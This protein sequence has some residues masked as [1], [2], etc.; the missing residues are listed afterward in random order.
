MTERCAVVLAGGESRRMKSRLSKVLH[1]ILGVTVIEHVL[2]S[3]S[4]AGI[5]RVVIVANPSNRAPLTEL[6]Q[7][8]TRLGAVRSRLEVV[9]QP[10]ALGTANAVEAALPRL[11][12]RGAAV[13]LCGDAPLI[14]PATLSGFL[15]AHA[16][17]GSAVG[18][19]SGLVDDPAGYGRIVRDGEGRF[20]GIVEEAE[21]DDDARAIREI[22]SGCIAFEIGALR[23]LLP[24][25]PASAKG[26][27]YLTAA[28]ELALERG[29][30]ARAYAKVEAEEILGINTRAQLAAATAVLRRRVVAGHMEAGVSF[31]DPGSAFIDRRARIGA[32]TVIEPW[33]VIEGPVEVGEGCRLGPFLRLRGGG[34]VAEGTRLGNF[35]EVVRSQVGA[36]SQVLHHAYLGDTTLGRGVNIGAGS[37]FANW[38]G[39]RKQAG[40]VGD[41]AFVGSGTVVV[42]PAELGA[43]AR[44]GAGAVVTRSIPAGETWV[45]V[46]ARRL[47]G[48]G[49][50]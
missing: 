43:R 2:L 20:S 42:Q 46:P 48:E 14:R 49:E 34:T 17:S 28:I 19:L 4:E 40:R 47:R 1:P 44:T 29:L 38:D 18:V 45:G 39:E 35:V 5:D 13:V 16:A 31:V 9:V 41:G 37:V 25:I 12:E 36:G 32:D 30:D 15:E 3:A 50:A 7:G 6:T 21:A 23:T 27:F 22:N 10:R 11:P 33:V 8:L 26:E 24:A